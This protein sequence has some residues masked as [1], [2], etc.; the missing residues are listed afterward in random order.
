MDF[1]Y[2]NELVIQ[3]LLRLPLGKLLILI[4]KDSVREGFNTFSDQ[5]IIHLNQ[6]NG[7]LSDSS[8]C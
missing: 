1:F 6:R 5:L 8:V 7:S 4:D 3:T 2:T